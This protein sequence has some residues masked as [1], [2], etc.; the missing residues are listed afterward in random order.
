MPDARECVGRPCRAVWGARNMVPM[1]RAGTLDSHVK[2]TLRELSC[3]PRGPQI[4]VISA[5]RSKTKGTITIS[6]HNYC[7][8]SDVLKHFETQNVQSVGTSI[9][10]PFK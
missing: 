5:T 4:S 6:P 7:N 3:H 1:E 2:E 10:F 9:C 8:H